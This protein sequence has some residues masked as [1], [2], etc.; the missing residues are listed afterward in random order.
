MKKKREN[1][2]LAEV[3]FKN[4]INQ[5]NDKKKKYEKVKH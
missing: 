3:K 4:K 2:K 5:R 1:K